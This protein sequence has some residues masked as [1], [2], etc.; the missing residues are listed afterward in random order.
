MTPPVWNAANTRVLVQDQ[1]AAAP[2]D[3]FFVPAASLHRARAVQNS[4]NF[5]LTGVKYGVR[6]TSEG[7]EMSRDALHS[8][9]DPVRSNLAL[10]AFVTDINDDAFGTGNAGDCGYC[11]QEWGHHKISEDIEVRT[12]AENLAEW[13]RDRAGRP[14][15][16]A[17]DAAGRFAGMVGV[18]RVDPVPGN[19]AHSLYFCAIS[20]TNNTNENRLNNLKNALGPPYSGMHM[21]R[22]LPARLSAAGRQRRDRGLGRRRA[23]RKLLRRDSR[24]ARQPPKS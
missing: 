18:L 16:R 5:N 11:G 2:N 14:T 10:S 19:I 15:Q 20:G 24:V 8:D 4:M 23:R 7:R 1:A 13:G 9:E 12:Y 22:R 3:H 6:K 17:T 21:A